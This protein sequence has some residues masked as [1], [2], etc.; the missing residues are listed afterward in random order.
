VEGQSTLFLVHPIGG[1]V[2][3]AFDMARHLEPNLAI[4]GLAASGLAEGEL[5]HASIAAM[6][7]I[8]LGAVRQVQSAG[9]YRLAGW[10]LGGMIA[11]EM[12]RQL[13]EAG[14]TVNFIG[15]I[16]TGSPA[17]LREQA[18]VAGTIVFDE[19]KALLNWIMDQHPNLA[20]KE[21][22]ERN[23]LIAL[24][25]AENLDAMIALCQQQ[26]LLSAQIDPG[27]VKR[28]L[29]VYRAGD[30]AANE[31]Q[32]QAMAVKVNLYTADRDGIGDATLG[33]DLTLGTSLRVTKIGGTHHSIVKAPHIERLANEISRDLRDEGR[34]GNSIYEHAD[35]ISK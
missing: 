19:C 30:V 33:W 31:Y 28:I 29:A 20:D 27:Q 1:E 17:Y 35:A 26:K 12:A 14:E 15:M 16:D 10:S 23:E 2:Q 7:S 8:Y 4:Y 3:Y 18:A 5:P 9:P 25:D 21:T 11:Y 34:N 22:S 6:A 24:A 32:P 13:R